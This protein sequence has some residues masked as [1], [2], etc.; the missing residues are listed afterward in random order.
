MSTRNLI[1]GHKNYLEATSLQKSAIIEGSERQDGREVSPLTWKDGE[2]QFCITWQQDED[3]TDEDDAY[4]TQLAQA[5]RLDLND[6][7]ARVCER[8]AGKNDT[9]MHHL[10]EAWVSSPPPDLDRILVAPHQCEALGRWLAIQLAR[11][12]QAAMA[13]AED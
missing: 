2:Y 12:F 9:P 5:Q 7:V 4:Q 10:L 6:I 3:E 11:G 1:S 13:L 8:L